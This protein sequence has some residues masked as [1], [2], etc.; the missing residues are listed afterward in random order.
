MNKFSLA[1]MRMLTFGVLL[2]IA[3]SAAAQQPYPSKPIRLISPYPPGG[4]NDTLSRLLAQKLTEGFGQ[5]VIV[6]NRP[7][8]NTII[9]T[10]V[11]A[12]APPDGYTI[13]LVGS[14]H[15]LVPRLLKAPYDPIKDFAPVATLAGGELVLLLNPRVPANNLKE[16]IALAKSKAG[17]L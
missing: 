7:G 16:F 17:A 5:Q 14:S 12:K 4:G 6:D 1:M 13:L 10:E 9:G 3:G 15:V 2:A 8:G 11:T